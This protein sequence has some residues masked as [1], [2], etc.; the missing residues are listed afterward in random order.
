MKSP[1][2]ECWSEVGNVRRGKT[3]PNPIEHA[4]AVKGLEVTV[5]EFSVR[6]V[7]GLGCREEFGVRVE[8]QYASSSFGE[9]SSLVTNSASEVE[10]S[11]ADKRWK[12]I[13]DFRPVSPIKLTLVLTRE[14]HGHAVV[15]RH[16]GRVWPTHQ[17]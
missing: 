6:N 17:R 5:S 3:A 4:E 12:Q 14:T 2:G 7:P 11:R 9:F 16:N 15:I 13:H 10:Y 1:V 8:A